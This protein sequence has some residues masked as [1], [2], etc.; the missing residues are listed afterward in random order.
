[1]KHTYRCVVISAFLSTPCMAQ[2]DIHHP[3]EYKI[4]EQ[5]HSEDCLFIG[6][7][8]IKAYF[9]EEH[10]EGESGELSLKI[11]GDGIHYQNVFSKTLDAGNG[12]T[13]ISF[14]A[15]SCTTD[16]NIQIQ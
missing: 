16:L 4:I 8:V 10:F 14:D 6:T 3:P 2:A 1:M 15:G 13:L 9:K 11:T 7:S 5:T 12:T